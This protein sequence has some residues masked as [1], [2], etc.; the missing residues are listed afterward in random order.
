LT[1]LDIVQEFSVL[2]RK[3]RRRKRQRRRKERTKLDQKKRKVKELRSLNMTRRP[4]C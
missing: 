3:R 1:V 4:N 2:C